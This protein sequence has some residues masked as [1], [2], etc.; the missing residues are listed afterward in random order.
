MLPLAAMNAKH[1]LAQFERT[2]VLI[3]HPALSSLEISFFVIHLNTRKI[4]NTNFAPHI[5]SSDAVEG[6]TR[7]SRQ[8]FHRT[9]TFEGH[10]QSELEATLQSLSYFLAVALVSSC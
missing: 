4:K 5:I 3:T 2:I 10:N 9:L 7:N 1:N 8:C 6:N